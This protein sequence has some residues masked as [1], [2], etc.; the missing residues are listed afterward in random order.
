MQQKRKQDTLQQLAAAAAA[1]ASDATLPS[2][3]I[4]LRDPA[5]GRVY[6]ANAETGQS[7]WTVPVPPA[8]PTLQV[9][10]LNES[11]DESDDD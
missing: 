6:Y 10:T 8:P 7:Q 5:S 3:W 11:D 2:G 1:P 9:P 4:E